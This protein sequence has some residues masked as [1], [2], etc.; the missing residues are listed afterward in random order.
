MAQSSVV[1]NYFDPK[2]TPAFGGAF[3]SSFGRSLHSPLDL[4]SVQP[5]WEYFQRDLNDEGSAANL[6]KGMLVSVTNDLVDGGLNPETELFE[7]GTYTSIYHGSYVGDDGNTITYSTYAPHNDLTRRTGLW[8]VYG[9]IHSGQ[10]GAQGTYLADRILTRKETERYFEGKL[11]AYYSGVGEWY[12]LTRSTNPNDI[13]LAKKYHSGIELGPDD[14]LTYG[15]IFNDYENNK[16][17]GTY[18]HA[19]GQSTFAFNM[20]AHAEGYNTIAYGTNSHAEGCGSQTFG[21]TYVDGQ[22]DNYKVGDH[23]HAEGYYTKAV[24]TASHTEGYYTTTYVSGN[25]PGIMYYGEYAHAEGAFT[26]AYGEAAHAEGYN[27]YARASYSHA[28]G[29]NTYAGIDPG[30]YG[31]HAEGAACVRGGTNTAMVIA[32]G[33]GA[34]AEGCAVATDGSGNA[35]IKADGAGAHAE[36]YSYGYAQVTATGT[37]AHAEGYGT[38]ANGDATHAEGTNTKANEYGAHAEGRSTVAS[39]LAAH[40]EGT[41]TNASGRYS[42]AE[43]NRTKAKNEAAHAEGYDTTASGEAAHAE[44][45]ETFATG[46]FSHTSGKCTRAYNE[47]EFAIGKYNVS[48][49]PTEDSPG[50]IFTIGIGTS[51]EDRKNAMAIHNDGTTYI[52]N[53][54]YIEGTYLGVKGYQK[55]NIWRGTRTEYDELT[56][57]DKDCIYVITKENSDTGSI[58]D[59]D[60]F[61]T[62]IEYLEGVI[63][64]LI[65]TTIF[66]VTGDGEDRPTAPENSIPQAVKEYIDTKL[67]TLEASILTKLENKATVWRGTEEDYNDIE[68]KDPNTIYLLN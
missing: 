40:A 18:S 53:T 66:D 28:E 8:Y 39:G 60:N 31:A 63:E 62:R 26:V 45:Y 41:N 32:T 7:S 19:E 10:P 27:T 61:E 48:T 51:E 4:S 65:D 13:E 21:V 6:Y 58:I 12:Q 25:D 67:S 64:E 68:S 24:G 9:Y 38:T 59:V 43:G 30:D 47:C 33:I 16:A 35:L 34:H 29:Y 11:G 1:N 5:D 37:G 36:G 49:N 50:S 3:S 14:Y 22:H 46:D 20:N 52:L 42:H 54:P 23:A 15:E 17:T 2:V 56:S 44:G 55:T 57:Y